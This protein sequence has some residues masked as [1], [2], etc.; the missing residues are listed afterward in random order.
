MCR[1]RGRGGRRAG[2]GFW[3][4]AK[5][6]VSLQWP[7]GARKGLR[8]MSDTNVISDT[9]GI[10]TLRGRKEEGLETRARA[11]VPPGQ[12]ARQGRVATALLAPGSVTVRSGSHP[13][14]DTCQGPHT[15][16]PN[17]LDASLP[18]AYT[19]PHDSRAHTRPRNAICDPS[20]TEGS[21]QTHTDS[22]TDGSVG[23][24]SLRGWV[25][26]TEEDQDRRAQ[27]VM[28]FASIRMEE[29][30]RQ[31]KHDTGGAPGGLGR[32]GVRLWLRS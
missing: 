11:T 4:I 24:C 1:E 26:G 10:H 23:V 31:R 19:H 16:G 17:S 20:P 21:I 18:T 29:A 12:A 13:G 3:V 5:L 2:G 14:P 15:P 28:D 22:T 9:G 30:G 32:L 6:A 8:T 25:C 7:L 27:R